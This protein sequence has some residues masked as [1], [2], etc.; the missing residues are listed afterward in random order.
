VL[1]AASLA[2]FTGCAHGAGCVRCLA[3]AALQAEVGLAA[4]FPIVLQQEPHLTQL[5]GLADD[6]L[7][8]VALC[9]L[10]CSR[11]VAAKRQNPAQKPVHVHG[12]APLGCGKTTVLNVVG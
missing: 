8:G 2:G 4:A 6:Q 1:I 9:L 7:F 12:L 11:Y 5:G 10:S 3:L